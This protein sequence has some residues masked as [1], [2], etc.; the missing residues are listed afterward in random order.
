MIRRGF[1]LIELL[2]VI[3]II[4]ILA[5]ILLPALARAREAA[6]RASCQNNLK[7]MGLVFHMYT[8]EN[9]GKYPHIKEF[10][11]LGDVT[12]WN[13]IPE[14]ES[15]YPEYL[16]D[17]NVLICPSNPA[18]AD[19]LAQYDRGETQYEAWVDA[20]GFSNNG[21][22]E[23]CEINSDP[24]HYY[25]WAFDANLFQTDLDFE[26]FEDEVED[27]A[28]AMET[29]PDIVDEE[30]E[31]DDPVNGRLSIPRLKDGIERFFITDINNPAGSAQA[32]STI[33]VMHDSIS[34]EAEH[35]NHVPGGAN[36]LY[37]DGH[38]A[39]V[40]W[41]AGEGMFPMNEAGLILHEIGAP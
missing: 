12:V 16:T 26:N 41:E 35:F 33:V 1:T 37:M 2:V 39:F 5:A 24:Y 40:K 11:C 15:I 29:D 31:L 18:G 7:Q 10:D 4:G 23:P 34:D 19:A 27:L 25:G 22:V 17:P 20:P 36:I 38:V 3:A 32:Q 8:S 14:P 30:F 13:Q 9:K 6:R 28:E 21:K